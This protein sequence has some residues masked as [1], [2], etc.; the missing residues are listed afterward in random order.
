MATIK[1]LGSKSS[2]RYQ[3]RWREASGRQ[4]A[5]SFVRKI[6]AER[7]LASVTVDTA[8]GAYI[9]PDAGKETVETFARRWAEGQPWRDSSRDRMMHVIDAQIAGRFGSA[10]LRAVRPSDVQAW[11]GEMSAAGLASSTVESYF[12][13]LAA[14][15]RAARRDRLIHESPTDGIRLPRSDRSRS[16]LVPLTTAQVLQLADAVPDRYRAL[17]LTSSGLGLRQGEAC[18]LT[19]DRVDFLRRSVRIDRQLV[20]PSTGP[21]H[22]G[23]V[24]TASSNRVVTLPETVA[25]ELAAH[26]ARFG[27]GDDGLIFT[28]STGAPLRRSTW[29][30][31]FA[32]AS[33]DTGISASS[34]DLRHHC[35]S[36]LISASCSV[37]AVQHFLGHKNASETL[38]TYSHLWPTDEGRIRD[39]IDAGMRAGVHEMCT[40]RASGE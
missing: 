39:A 12:R 32:R 25:D 16:A 15:M 20:T 36:L 14:I 29:Q 11:V 24:K 35:A 17:V 18:G 26:L 5:R 40:E 4:R 23:P 28:S 2:P 22:L 33:R 34:H 8:R 1:N 30:A 38:D 31:A 6:D 37:T 21:V 19:V 13:V 9:D 10:P 7:F 27:A 3:A